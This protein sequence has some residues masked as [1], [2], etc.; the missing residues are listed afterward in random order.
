[1]VAFQY[2]EWFDA[3]FKPWAV[4]IVKGEQPNKREQ[5]SASGR[6]WPIVNEL[7]LGLGGTIAIG[8]EIVSN[9]FDAV[10][11]KFTFFQLESDAV[12]EED[13]ADATQIIEERMKDGGP[14]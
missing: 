11:K 4:G 5:S 2:A 6:N 1:M 3:D 9:I 10:G 12:F 8:G 13:G 14:E 7:E